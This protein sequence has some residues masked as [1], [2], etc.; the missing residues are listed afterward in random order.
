MRVLFDED[1]LC[2][3]PCASC[4]HMYVEDIWGE[5]QCD[6]KECCHY[7]EY[8]KSQLVTRRRQYEVAATKADDR[9]EK[10]IYEAKA[11]GLAEALDIMDY[12]GEY[13]NE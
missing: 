4:E 10:L 2:D 3:E 6:E 11:S 8:V 13:E 1:Y 5:C 7:S 12:E 9:D